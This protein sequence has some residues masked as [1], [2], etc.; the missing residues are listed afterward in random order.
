MKT[1]PDLIKRKDSIK[2]RIL[3]LK[4]HIKNMTEIGGEGRLMLASQFEEKVLKLE[5]QLFE[6]NLQIDN[7]EG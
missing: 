3:S 5:Q 1:L 6:L 2:E 4:G 7:H